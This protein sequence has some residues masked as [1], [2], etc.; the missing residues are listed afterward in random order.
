MKEQQRFQYLALKVN[1][2]KGEDGNEMVRHDQV[3]DQVGGGEKHPV[4]VESV[5]LQEMRKI[6]HLK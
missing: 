1:S 6:S 2:V 3:Q 5:E 4:G